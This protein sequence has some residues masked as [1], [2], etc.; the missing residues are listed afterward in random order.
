MLESVVNLNLYILYG[1]PEKD[2]LFLLHKPTIVQTVSYLW[3]DQIPTKWSPRRDC[4]RDNK[5]SEHR[6]SKTTQHTTSTVNRRE[7]SHQRRHSLFTTT[8]YN[9]ESCQIQRDNYNTDFR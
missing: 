4:Q 7:S 6:R 9:R 3:P 8:C 1:E 5:Q 2:I